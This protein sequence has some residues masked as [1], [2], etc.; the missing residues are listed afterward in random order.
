MTENNIDNSQLMSSLQGEDSEMNFQNVINFVWRLKWWILVCAFVAIVV[1]VFYVKVQIPSYRCGAKVMLLDERNGNPE[2]SVLADLTGSRQ[3]KRIDDEIYMLQSPNLMA[4][5]VDELGLNTRYYQY[6]LPLFH[7]SF[8]L[9]RTVFNIKKTEF[10]LDSP[11]ELSL[12]FDELYSEEDRPKYINLEFSANDDATYSIDH[13]Y[14]GG[15]E[16]L[17]KKNNVRQYGDTLTFKGFTLCLKKVRNSRMI[18]GDSF[19]VTY[20]DSSSLGDYNS[21]KLSTSI[22]TGVTGRA[23]NVISL[24]FEDSKPL[25]GADI[26]NA[27]IAVYNRQAR[28][29]KSQATLRSLDFISD[30]ID[31]V[32][33]ELGTVEVKY[34]DY[35]SNHNFVLGSGGEYISSATEF[36]TKLADLRMQE[37]FLEMIKNELVSKGPDDYSVIPANVGLTDSGLN[38]MIGAYNTLAVQRNRLL[39]NSSESNPSVINYS[40]QVKEARAGLE[41]AIRNLEQVY[42]V[43]ETELTS[44]QKN[45]N[46]QRSFIPVRQFDLNQIERKQQIIEPM[47][48]SLNQKREEL[49]LS[50][51][52]VTDNVRVIEPARPS[53][54]KISPNSKHIYLLSLLIGCL[55]PIGIVLLRRMMRTKVESKEDIKKYVQSPLIA[56]IPMNNHSCKLIACGNRDSFSESFRMLRSN[57]Q[58]MPGKVIQVTSSVSGEGKSVIASNLAVSLSHIGKRVV[59]LG[60]DFRKPSLQTVFSEVY[61]DGD[62]SVVGYLIGKI[63]KPSEIALQYMSDGFSLDIMFSGVIPPNPSELLSM[64]RMANL[65]D[66]CKANYDFV[67]CDSTPYF[68]VPDASLVNNYADRTLYVIR[69]DF[70]QIRMLHDISESLDKGHLKNAAVVLNGLNADAKKYRYG[71]GYGYGYGSGSGYGYGYGY[72]NEKKERRTL[73]AFPIVKKTETNKNKNNK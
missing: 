12:D 44:R 5:V 61:N 10:Y 70:S 35:Q 43:R 64:D 4:Q 60:L 20:N 48:I 45:V 28:E 17:F 34:R 65:I 72:G 68:P 49:Q 59:L 36:E 3:T 2:L 66:Y 52:S 29:Y 67:I 55:L 41:T 47:F 1:A 16:I 14:I 73:S 42:S 24:S 7:T 56:T 71:Y 46:T 9:F 19:Q 13:L 37:T 50:L 26:L 39:V 63:D 18:H 15:Q 31:D 69:S 53:Y 25:R 58:Y 23:T 51:F 40:L 27:M 21:S 54:S 57:M 32:S 33:R 11:V 62:P 8:P 38:Q 6:K 30:R 22:E